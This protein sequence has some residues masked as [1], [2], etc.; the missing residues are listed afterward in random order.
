MQEHVAEMMDKMTS[1]IELEVS[2]MPP[3]VVPV[4][5]LH[6]QAEDVRQWAGKLL[7]FDVL[8]HSVD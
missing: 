7:G 4:V 6:Q 2:D 8:Q 5:M 3:I 1:L